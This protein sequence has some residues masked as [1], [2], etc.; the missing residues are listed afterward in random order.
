MADVVAGFRKVVQDLLVPELKAVQT[1]IRHVNERLEK[2]EKR[3]DEMDKR[4][5]ALHEEI[6]EIR[7]GQKHIAEKIDTL[8]EK[9][10]EKLDVER[11][12]TKLE[13]ALQLSK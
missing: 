8:N 12:L 2:L 5:A 6:L 10:N 7:I 1:E 4:F 9:L 13:T 3:F 11:R